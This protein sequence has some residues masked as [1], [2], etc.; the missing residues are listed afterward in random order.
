MPKLARWL[1]TS[2]SAGPET[3]VK[4]LIATIDS[5][6]QQ[7][8]HAEARRLGAEQT[9]SAAAAEAHSLQ[10]LLHAELRQLEEMDDR[11]QAAHA[12][13]DAGLLQQAQRSEQLRWV[14]GNMGASLPA[15]MA[16]AASLAYEAA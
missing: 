4:R 3:A 5:M 1:R 11:Q 7:Q 13:L 6:Q 10:V 8:A 16:R 15:L 12:A 14:P 2:Y 9:A